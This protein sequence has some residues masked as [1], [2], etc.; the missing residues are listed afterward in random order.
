MIRPR[1]LLRTGFEIMGR[2]FFALA[3]AW[4]PLS[5]TSSILQ[6]APLEVTA[7]AA[8]LLGRQ[9]SGAGVARAWKPFFVCF[10]LDRH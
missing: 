10:G 6:A 7:G 2:L 5:V 8:L 9:E 3:L 4:T 1:L